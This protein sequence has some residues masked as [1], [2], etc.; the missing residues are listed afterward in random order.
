MTYTYDSR[1][2]SDLH[3]DAR[4]F[5]PTLHWMV[6]WDKMS[7][8]G[9]QAEWDSLCAELEAELDSEKRHQTAALAKFAKAIQQCREAGAQDDETAIQWLLQTESEF[10]LRYGADYVAFDWGMAYDNPYRNMIGR[11]INKMFLKLEAA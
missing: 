8:A 6:E 5:R 1:I 11:V 10:D 3:K 9:K 7:P 2:V 4:G